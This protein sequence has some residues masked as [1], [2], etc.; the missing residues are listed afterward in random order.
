MT[1]R[2]TL[3]API[4]ISGTGLFSALPTSLTVSPNADSHDGI[5]FKHNSTIIHVHIDHLSSIPVHPAFTKLS[6]RCTSIAANSINIATIEHLM[7]ALVGLGIT[8]ATIELE[9]SSAHTEIPIMDGSSLD[10]VHAI[11]A[12]GICTLETH[13]QPITVS[14]AILI[15]QGDSSISIEPAITPSYSYTLEYN[16][17]SIIDTTVS[18]NGKPT[19]YINNIAPARTFCLDHE[20]D[21]MHNA[22]LFTHLSTSD[23]LVISDTGPINNTLRNKRECAYHKLLDLIGDLSL[24]GQPLVAK[25]TAIKSGHAMAHRAARAIVD[26]N[27]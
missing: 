10:F 7:S 26:Q 25:V 20:A 8:D 2:T 1:N 16:H 21:A 12:V 17:P 4:H 3:A 5:I 13:V 6:P 18:W 9:S 24:V 15:E 19:E 23:M 27:Q 14:K 22:G 11:N